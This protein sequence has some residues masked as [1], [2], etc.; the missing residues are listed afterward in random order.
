MSPTKWQ[1]G[2]IIQLNRGTADHTRVIKTAES[3]LKLPIVKLCTLPVDD[4]IYGGDISLQNYLFFSIYFGLYLH[5]SNSQIKTRRSA[6]LTQIIYL[7]LF[8]I[9]P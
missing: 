2:G 6:E 9:L 4:R 7:F 3:I 5:I 1:I 8:P